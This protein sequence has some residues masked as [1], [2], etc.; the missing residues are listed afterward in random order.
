MSHTVVRMNL[1][2]WLCRKPSQ[3][4]VLLLCPEESNAVASFPSC[5]LHI[6]DDVWP[7]DQQLSAI[8]SH[9]IIHHDHPKSQCI[10]FQAS[11]VHHLLS[12]SLERAMSEDLLRII[13]I[14]CCRHGLAS[15]RSTGDARMVGESRLL[16]FV[17]YQTNWPKKRVTSQWIL[18]A[19]KNISR[20]KLLLAYLVL[21]V[22][23][24][25]SL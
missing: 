10:Y 17:L 8:N 24:P 11:L 9:L 14:R 6:F 3:K 18:D 2:S 15:V 1:W 19:K 12:P 4:R 21:S 23:Q 22:C 20:F 25:N 16:H 7:L 5:R 13:F